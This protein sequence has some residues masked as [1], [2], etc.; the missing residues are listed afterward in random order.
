MLMTLLFWIGT[1]VFIE[2]RIIMRDYT[3]IAADFD[4]DENAVNHI[5]W[6]K[7]KGIIRFKDAHEIQQSNDSSLFC[8][9]KRSLK[10]RLDNSYKFVLIVGDHTN[11]V[12]KGGCQQC[13][14]YNSYGKYC[15]RGYSVDYRSYVKYECDKALENELE[16]VVLYNST[17]V[18]RELCPEVVRWKG[19]HKSMIY[20]GNDG[21]LY[22]DD[23]SIKMA[24]GC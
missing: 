4:N 16:I 21:K 6:M 11:T 5:H 10:F 2:R 14:S 22:W 12:T 20:R 1:V 9:I 13:E 8:S 24:F 23:S 15:A 17:I 7:D 18:D 19:L 3:Y